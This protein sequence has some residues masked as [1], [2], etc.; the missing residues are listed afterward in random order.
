MARRN[1]PRS[2][3]LRWLQAVQAGEATWDAIAEIKQ[4]VSVPVIANGDVK[5]PEDIARIKRHT[6]CDANRDADDNA[7]CHADLDAN[8][9]A[10]NHSD[11]NAARF[12]QSVRES[13]GTSD[14]TTLRSVR[15][16][17]SAGCER[18]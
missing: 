5:K 11:R 10:D 8:R 12:T 7:N 16:G 9:D 17:V 4:A 15:E 3:R 2:G 1:V 14:R 6:G 18:E 13:N